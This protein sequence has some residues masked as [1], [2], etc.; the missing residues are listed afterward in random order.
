MSDKN[1]KDS[2]KKKGTMY[3]LMARAKAQ[4]E[5]KELRSW[6]LGLKPHEPFMKVQFAGSTI[7]TLMPEGNESPILRIQ[8]KKEGYQRTA[9]C[10]MY[11]SHNKNGETQREFF[12]VVEKFFNDELTYIS[13]I[14]NDKMD[15]DDDARK[16][17]VNEQ[18]K[19]LIVQG[20]LQPKDL[21]TR[22]DSDDLKYMTKP[23]PEGKDIE[24]D[25][26]DL[27]YFPPVDGLD[28]FM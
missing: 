25:S 27:R 8:T 15:I 3:S 18:S 6:Y 22:P 20:R 21:D 14:G 12:V 24:Y 5:A 10:S 11:E 26:D 28:M 7:T 9:Y 1:K 2:K 4:K 19:F 13:A 16:L 23:H 17:F